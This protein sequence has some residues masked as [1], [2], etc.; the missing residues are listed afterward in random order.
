MA[1]GSSAK[2]DTG[3]DPVRERTGVQSLERAFSILTHIAQCDDGI[4][5][6][7]LSKL[8][9]L[10]TSTAFHLVRTMVELGV[11]RQDRTTKRY[12]LGRKI[13]SLAANASSEIDLVATA[14]P[15]LEALA[16]KT[17]ESSHLGL[18]SGNDVI[19]AARVAGSGAFQ[20]VERAG[21]LRPAHCTG[22]GKVLMAALPE[23]QFESWLQSA[24]LTASTPNT[25]TEPAQ[26]RTEIE[27]VRQAGVAFD[28]AEYDA[29]V[30][31]IAAPIW[32]FTG[33]V[34]GAIGVSGPIWRM[35]LQRMNELAQVIRDSAADLS[36]E[37]G[38]RPAEA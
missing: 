33:Q 27:R 6:A 30:R 21:G 4:N 23:T 19:V 25:I 20:L 16:Q 11:V 18:R 9:G 12:H 32:D 10:H 36:R 15:F 3:A 7:D 28:D 13:F 34:V 14:T 5:L 8:V 29:E 35:N 38:Y 24:P 2:V 31:C 22:L 17:G 26:L 37:L 1:V